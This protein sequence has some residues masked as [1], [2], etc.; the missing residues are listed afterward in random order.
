MN[1]VISRQRHILDAALSS[2]MRRKGRNLALL[3]AYTLLVFIIA[4]LL[5][6]VQALKREAALLLQNAPDLVVQRMM[7]GRQ[8]LV[9][10][11][12]AERIAAIRGVGSVAPRLWGYYFDPVFSASYT[13][14]APA[15]PAQPRGT[16]TI[17]SA[18]GRARQLQQ[19]DFLT[20]MTYARVPLFLRV[21]RLLDSS[22]ELLAADTMLLAETDFRELF[23]FPHGYATDLALTVTNPQ[24]TSTIAA[25]IIDLFPDTRPIRKDEMQRSYDAVF[26]WRGGMILVVLSVA[27][28]C[29]I[30]LAW[31]KAT[32]LSADERREIGILKSIGWDTGDVLLLKFWEGGAISLTAFMVGAILSYCHLFF[33]SA[34]LFEQAFKG[35]SVLYPRFRLV[36]VIDAYQFCILFFLTVVP[37]AAATVIP[38]WSAA[39][40]PPDEAM[41][42]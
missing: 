19:G 20:L 24:E 34:G 22:S 38:S 16:V 41:R 39:A 23:R 21:G 2:L 40:A 32:G 10:L 6:F 11:R 8:D 25:K 28:L 31:D 18:L 3:A 42:S 30:I 35:W 29:F 37:Y 14:I 33:F 12:Y 1:P 7:A 36:P 27:I 13:L 5:F 26:D 4:S 15:S 9:P 17:G